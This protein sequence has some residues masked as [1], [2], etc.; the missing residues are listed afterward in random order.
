MT[1]ASALPGW[2]GTRGHAMADGERTGGEGFVVEPD[3]GT[4]FWFLNTLTLNKVD[5]QVTS[6]ALSVVDHR[7]PAGYGPPPHVHHGMDEVFYVIDGQF[8]GFCGEQSW[9]AGPGAIVFLPRDVPHGFH[10]SDNGPGRALVI[11]AP[12]NFDEFVAALG[13]PAGSLDLP[14]PA[15]PDVARVIAIAAAHGIHIL[16]PPDA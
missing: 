11:V 5:S 12:G 13:E 4:P 9:T 1:G 8:D 10:V 3:G 15:A 7:V 16:P 6:G 2:W 14:E